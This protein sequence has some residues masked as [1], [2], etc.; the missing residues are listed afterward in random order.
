MEERVLKKAK[1]HDDE[2][3]H[4]LNVYRYRQLDF[5]ALCEVNPSLRPF[6]L[7]AN[8]NNNMPWDNPE[9]LCELSKALLAYD[10]GL[11]HVQL[12]HNHLCPTITSRLSYILYVHDLVGRKPRL[13]I[14]PISLRYTVSSMGGE[15]DLVGLDIGCGASVI[16]PLL[17]NRLFGWR[18]VGSELD[19]ESVRVA[20]ENV[21]NCQM[22]DKITVVQVDSAEDAIWKALK[23]K[24]R[25]TNGDA[26]DDDADVEKYWLQ[27]GSLHFVMSNPPFFED[28]EKEA[29]QHPKR[30]T[31][32]T[33]FES[34]TQ[35]GEV[36]FIMRMAHDSM[37]WQHCPHT[38]WFTSL[39]GKKK[40]VAE[41]QRRLGEM[42]V[43]CVTS[44]RL[45]QGKTHRWVVAWCFRR[46]A[47]KSPLALSGPKDAAQLYE[48]CLQVVQDMGFD[49]SSS[50][51]ATFSLTLHLQ[52]VFSCRL[53]ISAGLN[54]NTFVVVVTLTSGDKEMFQQFEPLLL[55]EICEK[56]GGAV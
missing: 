20:R 26:N 30:H 53:Q 3:M 28:H 24:R 37:S 48:T 23:K 8:N 2:L 22:T 42:G 52:D 35:G 43:P 51:R 7:N 9:A 10:F 12:P 14:D 25:E 50:S 19:E 13:H 16:Y 18:F 38:V 31:Q 6:L 36:G 45:V 5:E 17:G 40:T 41:V 34:S 55:K 27:E 47:L 15:E 44:T 39:C 54:P 46:P 32:I 4:P 11:C 21:R 1:K 56:S 29:S 33:A 49:T